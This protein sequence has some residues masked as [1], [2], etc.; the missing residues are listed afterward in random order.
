MLGLPGGGLTVGGGGL[1]LVGIVIYILITVL[2][3]GSSARSA[4]STARPSRRHRPARCSPR[5]RPAPMP[6]RARTAASWPTSTACR[7][8]GQGAL[9]NYTPAKTVFFSGSTPDG[10]RNGEHRRRPLLLPGGQARLHRPRLLRRAANRFGAQGGSFAQAYVLAHEYGHHVQD[11]LGR[12]RPPAPASRAR[13]G[14]SVRTELQADCFA[15]VWAYHA[16]DRLHRRPDQAD[17][18]DALNAAAAVGDD[19]IQAESQGRVNPET[20]THG[21]SAQRQHWFTAG[22]GGTRAAATPSPARSSL[23]R[24]PR[25]ARCR[26]F[27]TGRRAPQPGVLEQVVGH[28]LERL[29]LRGG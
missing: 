29:V 15:G 5:A 18:A 1:G 14:G 13:R 8:T 9:A 24:E 3:K 12:P 11:L 23:A 22:L 10:L 27:A 2:S 7:S 4:G 19:R 26:A 21:S 28:R 20:W 16:T 17:I 25:T 6:T